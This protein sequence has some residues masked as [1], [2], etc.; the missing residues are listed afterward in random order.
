MVYRRSKT[1]IRRPAR[2]R[3]VMRK[4]TY[5]R[6]TVTRRTRSPCVCPSELTPTARFAMAQIDPFDT[7]TQGAKVPDS[8]TI[9]SL[10]NVD[11]DQ[12][13][14][15]STATAADLNAIAFFP[16]YRYATLR[17]G[18][19][20][21]SVNWSINAPASRRNY[22]TVSNQIEGIRPVAHAIRMSSS[23]AP[24][25]ATGFVHVGIAVESRVGGIANAVPD[26]PTTVNEMTGLP[27]YRRFTLASLTQS[28][29]T[30]IN[31][32]IDESAFRYDDPDSLPVYL[33]EGEGLPTNTF[34]FGSSWG[35]LV[36]LVEGAEISKNILSFEHILHSEM[37]PKRTAFVLGTQAAP[38]SPGTMS[39]VSSMQTGS[40]FTHTEA[41]QETYVAEN[42]GRLARGAAQ[43]GAMVYENVAIPVIEAVG[44]PMLQ[45]AKTKAGQMAVQWLQGRGGLPG[46]TNPGRALPASA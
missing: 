43:A 16:A 40:E 2:R 8:N 44:P 33:A 24:T 26:L 36:V 13:T 39:A 32:W 28:P 4:R 34:N 37:I 45:F 9:P 11:Q 46:I 3:R 6:R 27:H 7:Q 25:T 35:T 1:N 30:V 29:I 12:V 10:A 18:I 14:M 20:A 19:S 23:V 22:S 42:L 15:Q 5:R 31:K 17:A 21:G 41:E 38:N